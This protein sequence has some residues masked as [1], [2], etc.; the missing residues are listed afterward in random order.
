MKFFLIFFLTFV[1]ILFAENSFANSIRLDGDNDKVRINDDEFLDEFSEATWNLWVKQDRYTDKAGLIGKYSTGSGNRAYL[2]RTVLNN[3]ISVVMSSDGINT[4]QY[5]SFSK[6]KCGVINNNEWTMITVTYDGKKIIYYRNGIKCD[7]DIINIYKIHNSPQPLILGGGNNIFFNGVIDDFIFYNKS[8]ND[9]QI[10]RIYNESPHGSNLGQSITALTYHDID[11]TG[12]DRN[13][14]ST[15]K[16]KEQ[17]SY[18]KSS[19]F[20]TISVSDYNNWRKN[21]FVMPKQPVIL[22]FDDG[23]ISVY[24]KAKP[25]MDSFNLIGTIMTVTNYANRIQGGP[26]YMHWPELED[27]FNNNWGIESHGVNHTNMLALD[28]TSFRYQLETSGEIIHNKLNII[29]SSF[30]FPFHLANEKYT[31]ICGEYYDLCWTWGE[32]PETPEYIYKST[33]GKNYKSLK[34]TIIT[35]I[36]SIEMFKDILAKDTNIIGDWKMEENSGTITKDSSIYNNDGA[37][38]NGAIFVEE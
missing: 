21:Q 30:T 38:L 12:K 8:L 2:I 36:T 22:I 10:L 25:I 35:N 24:T 26:S 7:S 4:E 27:L 33:S 5:T 11:E 6:K 18:L 13:S 19:G 34:R 23:R 15:E 37:L 16:F 9:E 28:E 14:I 31:K 3:S 32:E 29:P 20:K 1:L 17:M